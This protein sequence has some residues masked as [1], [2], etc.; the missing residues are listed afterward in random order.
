MTKLPDWAQRLD[1]L[2][3]QAQ[4]R[5]FEW[6]VHDCCLWAADAV[7]AQTGLDPAADLRGTYSDA[8][9]AARVLRAHGGLRGVAVRGGAP[10]APLF[11]ATG[12]VGLVRDERRPLLAVC[13]GIHWL[14][15]TSAGLR[16]LPFSAALMVWGVGRG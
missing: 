5:P 10:I 1:A 11:A 7:Q 14:A 9:G 2:V 6:G 16:A 13:A 12:D 4:L 15:V 3:A 8:A